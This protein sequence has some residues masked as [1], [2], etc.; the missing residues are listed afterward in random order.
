MSALYWYIA[1][2]QPLNAVVF[3]FDGILIGANDM[4]YMFKAMAVSAFAVFAPAALVFVFWLDLGLAGAWLAYN[5]LMLGR[6]FTLWPRYRSDAW[7]RSITSAEDA[8]EQ[9]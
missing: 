8:E 6:F 5:G 9:R 2:I 3:V 1:L 4:A 7:L